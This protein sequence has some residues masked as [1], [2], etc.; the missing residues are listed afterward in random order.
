MNFQNLP[1]DLLNFL[2]TKKPLLFK[3]LENL[4]EEFNNKINNFIK[5]ND[6]IFILQANTKIEILETLSSCCTVG[7]Q[8]CNKIVINFK[9]I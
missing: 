7:K 4:N 6:E 3:K 8:Y 1:K 9:V 5:I 2:Y